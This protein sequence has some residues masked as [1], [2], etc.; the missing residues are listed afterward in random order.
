M[1]DI[2]DRLPPGTP[3]EIWF[4]DEARVIQ[5]NKVTPRWAKRGSRPSAPHH[6]R[7]IS[8]RVGVFLRRDLPEDGQLRRARARGLVMPWCDRHA[9]TAYLDEIS[10]MVAPGAHAV[11][12]LDQAGWHMSK[13]LVVPDNIALMPLPPRSPELNPVACVWQYIRENRLSNRVLSS[14]EDIVARSCEAWNKRID[15]PWTIITVRHCQ[16]AH[17]F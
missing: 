3:V 10:R 7:T 17:G 5:K 2:R 14:D 1:A 15:R 12:I 9:M 16:W 13:A 4:Q 11:V 6:Q 8:V